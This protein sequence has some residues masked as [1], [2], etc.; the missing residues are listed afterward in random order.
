VQLTR[1][2]MRQIGA[3]VET[4]CRHSEDQEPLREKA[5][6]GRALVTV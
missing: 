1:V 5:L 6:L 4:H 3:S 2:G